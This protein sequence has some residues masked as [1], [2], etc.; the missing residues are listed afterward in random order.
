MVR[1]ISITLSIPITSASPCKGSPTLVNTTVAMIEAVPGTP[2]VPIVAMAAVIAM[3][4]Y[5][6]IDKSMPK[7]CAVKIH[8]IA[9]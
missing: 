5:C 6:W 9:G 1:I 3:R 2:A 8:T 4:T 7:I